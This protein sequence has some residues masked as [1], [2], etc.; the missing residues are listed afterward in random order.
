MERNPADSL[1]APTNYTSR[2]PR[3]HQ[4]SIRGL[5]SR[6]SPQKRRNRTPFRDCGSFM[7]RHHIER[8]PSLRPND[9]VGMVF[10]DANQENHFYYRQEPM[11][12]FGVYQAPWQKAIDKDLNFLEAAGP[13]RD[14]KLCPED[15]VAHGR[16]RDLPSHK[17]ASKAE[18]HGWQEMLLFLLQRNSLRNSLWRSSY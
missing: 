14:Q 9:I 17:A 18:F 5:R 13:E 11:P 1:S 4:R 2:T 7:G 16:D 15:W 3:N 12:E 10:I 8:V 6:H